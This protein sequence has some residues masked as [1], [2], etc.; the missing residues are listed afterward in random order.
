MENS[1]QKFRE[2]LLFSRNQ[3]FYLK[4]WKLWRAPTT[5]DFNNICWNFA[6][7]PYLPISTKACV[8][9]LK[10]CLELKLFA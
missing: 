8:E 9:F 10:F 2:A 3:V 1:I 4:N 5:I 7:V 6:H